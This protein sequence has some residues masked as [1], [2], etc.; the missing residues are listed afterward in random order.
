TFTLTF[1]ASTLA[2][3]FKQVPEAAK[4][5]AERV[6]LEGVNLEAYTESNASDHDITDFMNIFARWQIDLVRDTMGI[7]LEGVAENV[8]RLIPSGRRL[9]DEFGYWAASS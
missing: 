9:G 2:E 1:Q 5:L 6:G 3:L 4:T 8:E 7:A